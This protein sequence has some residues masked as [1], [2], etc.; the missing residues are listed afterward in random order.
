MK[1]TKENIEELPIDK[2][3]QN[4]LNALLSDLK[5]INAGKDKFYI[6]WNEYH[7]EYSPEWTEPCPDYYGTYTVRFKDD[8]RECIGTE[9]D[10]REL[11][12]ALCMLCNYIDYA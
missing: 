7:T 5:I 12:M 3:E 2:Y 4:L 6:D 1:V 8:P 9:M 11:D 10:I